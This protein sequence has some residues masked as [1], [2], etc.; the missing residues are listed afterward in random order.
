MKQINLFH[1]AGGSLMIIGAA[2]LVYSCMTAADVPNVSYQFFLG[3]FILCSMGAGMF[4]FNS[5]FG[6]DEPEPAYEYFLF[7][8][9]FTM[10]KF[11]DNGFDHFVAHLCNDGYNTW[12]AYLFNPT[13]KHCGQV[14]LETS[15][16]WAY[17]VI[18][19]E[20]YEIL[21]AI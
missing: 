9:D 18:T 5:L 1:V 3:F 13:E 21:I 4:S 6:K 14:L 17:R 12:E 19:K 10:R 11:D 20:Q 8:D 7:A 16:A 2:C 15:D